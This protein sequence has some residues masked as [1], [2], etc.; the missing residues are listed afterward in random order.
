MSGG[1]RLGFQ[2]IPDD[3]F[4]VE[5]G[6]IIDRQAHLSGL[7]LIPLDLDAAE[8]PGVDY[9]AVLE[10]ILAQEIN[11]LIM[12]EIPQPLIRL[13]T[14]NHIPIITMV[15]QLGC[16]SG[17]CNHP[18][19]TG[20]LGVFE[21]AGMVADFFRQRL[22]D[23]GN[24]LV[25]GGLSGIGEDG[26]TLL[27]G[28]NQ[29][30]TPC[31]GITL[32]HIPTFWRYDLAY[33]QILAGL[34]KFTGP[35]D[36][37]FGLSDTLALAAREAAAKFG[38]LK[39]ETLI[40][41]NYGEPQALSAIVQGTMAATVAVSTT[42][43][44]GRVIELARQAA[45]GQTIPHHFDYKRVLVTNAN[46]AELAVQKL[47]TISELPNQLIGVN[48]RR[49][50]QQLT[51]LEAS[52]AINRQV[53]AILDRHELTRKIVHQIREHFDY[54]RVNLYFWSEAEGSL[55]LDEQTAPDAERV[56]VG[57]GESKVLAHVLRTGK[58]VYVPDMRR[59]QRFAL[60]EGWPELRT[61][62]VMPVRFRDKLLC[63]LDLQSDR[64]RHHS[65]EELLGLQVVADQLAVAIQNAALY[66]EAL[67][68]RKEAEKADK[69]KTL[70]LANVS[71]EFRTPLNI[72]LGYTKEALNTPNPYGTE[73]PLEL[74]SDLGRI[75]RSGEHM[76]R[77]ISDLLDLSRAEIDELEI[78]PEFMDIRPTLE[79][80]F[81]S[82]AEL[83]PVRPGV[84][85]KFEVPA[86]LPVM[87]VD[88]GRL[89]QVILN[90]LSNASKFTEAGE[91]F[92]AVDVQPPYI[93]IRVQ[94]TGPGISLEQQESIFDPFIVGENSRRNSG[95]IGL[96][97]SITRHLVSLHRGHITLNSQ[98]GQGSVFNVFLPLPNLTG[99]LTAQLPG[100]TKILVCISNSAQLPS[101]MADLASR[102]EGNF[103]KINPA[104]VSSLLPGLSPSM[105]AWDATGMAEDD[106]QA[107][108]FLRN[109]PRLARLPLVLY[110]NAA[111]VGDPKSVTNIMLKPLSGQTLSTILT[112][113]GPSKS[114][115]SVLLV[116]DDHE[117][118]DLYQQFVTT[119]LPGY[120]IYR[121][122]SGQ[123]ALDILQDV[124]PSL[125][126]IDLIM[127]EIA[128]MKVVDWLRGN[129][130]TQHVPI[131]VISGKMLSA[132]H[133]K[134]L[135][136][137][138]LVYQPKDILKFE[139]VAHTLKQVASGT[140]LLSQFNSILV[141]RTVTYLQDNYAR[142]VTLHEIAQAVGTS[143]NNLSEIFHQEMRIS[144]W[145]FLNRY[146]I[147]QA[148]H[149][150]E[151]SDLNIAA[152]AAMVGFEDPAYFS[153]V[154]HSITDQS[155]KAYR[156]DFS[157]KA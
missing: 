80:V 95:G 43:F 83:T 16:H 31:S 73:L 66:S 24:V 156:L 82:V 147:K 72:I 15:P 116:D 47:V 118:L 13:L 32:H 100:D 149:L 38:L 81:F 62:F 91:I 18:N 140:P 25:V 9:T 133:V 39:P 102:Y 93:H 57:A 64:V 7:N 153:R 51:Q 33:P 96:G 143:K 63:L 22:Q 154:F 28:I 14:E 145:Q 152:I 107:M 54:S 142:P 98:P 85:W 6:M 78:F 4:W 60:D 105:L 5:I 26:R 112:A 84:E 27:A 88:P 132:E 56:L 59:S 71:H 58:P 75:Y 3:P 17:S 45:A 99:Q 48:R 10:E 122:D 67:A 148:R 23:R 20:P 94:D 68:A 61:R 21:I 128:G 97:L 126:I 146:R 41:G 151:T 49:E 36:A 138:R 65:R 34:Q 155:P 110:G 104:E 134:Q 55:Y 139:E 157:H 69:L 86:S 136:H 144:I 113:L 137:P 106:W 92:L 129:P 50:Q 123:L 120:I 135:D 109:H 40:V 46:V 87:Q 115:G 90:L 44:V 77:L 74:T 117:A 125:V 35:F 37:I 127:P 119:A 130:S 124:I 79:E 30:L 108:E 52:L 29:N 89:R 103:I 150:L 12:V 121:A 76:L 111:K 42:D 114:Q 1:I 11:S 8:M 70:V 101:E 2:I 141:K 131:L 53:G 19:V